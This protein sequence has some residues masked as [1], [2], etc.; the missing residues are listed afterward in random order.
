MP[1]LVAEDQTFVALDLA[2][3][4][5]DAGGKVVG[6]AASVAEVLDLL[7]TM[8]VAAAILDFNLV[9]GD[10]SVVVEVLANRNVPT[11]VH[12]GV[13]LP[14]GLVERFPGLMVQIKPCVASKLV[15]QLEAVIG[16]G[17]AGSYDRVRR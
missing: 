5:E 8:T 11:I 2:L 12:T 4:V 9:D 17:S 1:V 10:C 13:A 16:D 14:S 15:A 6:P 3:A 7:A